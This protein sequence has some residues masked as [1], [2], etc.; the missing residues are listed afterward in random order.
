VS[1]GDQEL[2]GYGFNKVVDHPNDHLDELGPFE[3]AEE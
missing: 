1:V 3:N 2:P